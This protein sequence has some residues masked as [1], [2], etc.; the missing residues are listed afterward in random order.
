MTAIRPA[1]PGWLTEPGTYLFWVSSFFRRPLDSG[2]EAIHT[3]CEVLAQL[4]RQGLV[5]TPRAGQ[6]V[7]R[8][9]AIEGVV[10][11]FAKLLSAVGFRQALD[12]ADDRE[13]TAALGYKPFIADGELGEPTETR[14]GVKQF[15]RLKRFRPCPGPVSIF[16][17]RAGPPPDS[18]RIED[19]RVAWRSQ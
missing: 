15:M 8:P 9:F 17:T 10:V 6:L 3:R 14:S 5:E 19:P 16:V 4:T 1:E 13:V 2:T 18:I 11:D 12:A 7:T